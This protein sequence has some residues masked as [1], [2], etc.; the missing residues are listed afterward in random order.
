M[1]TAARAFDGALILVEDVEV[2]VVVYAR[3]DGAIGV[4]G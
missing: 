3:D 4:D 2:L 1:E